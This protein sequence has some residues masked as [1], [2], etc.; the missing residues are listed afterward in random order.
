MKKLIPLICLLAS[1]YANAQQAWCGH[2]GQAECPYLPPPNIPSPPPP[3]I[4]SPPQPGQ[5][6]PGN[7]F[8]NQCHVS[9]VCNQYGQCQQIRICNY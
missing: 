7:V 3:N 4:P 5:L 8:Q 1:G 9:V 2:V 6:N